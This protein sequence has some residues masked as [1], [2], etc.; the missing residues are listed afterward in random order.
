MFLL[1]LLLAS[2][3]EGNAGA[4]GRLEMG[5][6]TVVLDWEVDAGVIIGTEEGVLGGGV[7]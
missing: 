2:D 1:R 6:G 3:E 5:M 7:A 4:D